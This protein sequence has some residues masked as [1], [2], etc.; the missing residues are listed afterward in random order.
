MTEMDTQIKHFIKQFLEDR[1]LQLN[2]IEICSNGSVGKN[3]MGSIKCVKVR[4][5][6]PH[7]F[8][9]KIAPSNIIFRNAHATKAIYLREIYTYEKIL[10]TFLELQMNYKVPLIFDSY[11]KY[12]ASSKVD[13]NEF[14]VM[15]NVMSLGYKN[16][17]N[18][19]F[20]LEHAVLVM[21]ALG[22]LHALSFGLRKK[23]FDAFCEI[24]N[25]ARDDEYQPEFVPTSQEVLDLF[26]MAGLNS[27]DPVNDKV[28]FEKFDAFRKNIGSVVRA[29]FT[30]MNHSEYA[31]VTHGD[32]WI[33]NFLFKYQDNQVPNDVLLLDWQFTRIGS[34]AFDISQ[35]FFICCGRKIRNLHYTKLLQTYYE[36][37]SSFLKFFDEEACELFPYEVLME[38]LRKFSVLGLATAL[39]MKY[40][41][42]VDHESLPKSDCIDDIQQFSKQIFEAKRNASLYNVEMRDVILDYI[43]FG[44]NI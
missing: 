14:V 34:P 11:P 13:L 12:C 43:N 9:V 29:A 22:K 6:K 27:L 32:C 28:A 25:N 1:N 8:V 37:L 7:N 15:K 42:T 41:L 26:T 40:L 19:E 10:P 33:A 17:D 20:D 4:G 5:K 18:F 30:E 16:Y 2:E 23:N 3:F 21:K 39:R 36:S 44:Y 38:H 24:R 35:F 31:V